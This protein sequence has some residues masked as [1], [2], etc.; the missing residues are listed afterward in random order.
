[1]EIKEVAQHHFQN[2]Y[3]ETWSSR[4]LLDQISFL[5]VSL[6]DNTRLI[7][8]F[9]KEEIK[10]AVWDCDNFKSPGPDGFNFHFIKTFWDVLKE[11]FVSFISEIHR[12]GKLVRGS[13]SSFLTLVP[14]IVSHHQLVH[15]RPISMINSMYKVVS[16]LLANRLSTVLQKVISPTQSGFLPHRNIMEGVLVANE[17]VDEVKRSSSSCIIFKADIEK[18]FDSVSWKYLFSMMRNMGFGEIWIGWIRECL[19]NAKVALSKKKNA[20][21]AIL[22]NESPKNEV[23]MSRELG[24]G[25]PLIP[26]LFLIAGEGLNGII[27]EAK[28]H[29]MLSGVKVGKEKIEITNL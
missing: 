3:S 18:A 6:V 19:S 12:N 17:L 5:Q 21:V 14:K 27:K 4:T 28:S 10:Q 22:V 1:M 23:S 2:L 8:P 29:G 13:N 9:S 24:Q 20:K 15:Y 25:D 7:A 26:L 11:D 16:K